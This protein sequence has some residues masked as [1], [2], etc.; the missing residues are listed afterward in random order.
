MIRVAPAMILSLALVSSPA[1][2]AVAGE[3]PTTYAKSSPQRLAR[4]VAR[5]VDQDGA[6]IEGV[7]VRLTRCEGPRF[8]VTSLVPSLAPP[9]VPGTIDTNC[10]EQTRTTGEDGEASFP[11]VRVGSLSVDPSAPRFTYVLRAEKDGYE[12]AGDVVTPHPARNDVDLVMFRGGS[13][14]LELVERA[15]AAAATGDFGAA[16]GAMSEAL[17]VLFEQ[18]TASGPVPEVLINWVRYLAHLQV[19]GANMAG[20]RESLDRLLELDPYDPFGLRT[21]GILAVRRQ[22][23]EE[24]RGHFGLYLLL[25]PDSADA[26]LVMGSLLVETNELDD[27]FEHLEQ[28]LELDRANPRVYRSLGMAH[29]RAD[30]SQEAI[31][32]FE[33]YLELAGDPPDAGQIRAVIEALRRNNTDSLADGV[34]CSSATLPTAVDSDTRSSATCG[35]LGCC[36]SPSPRVAA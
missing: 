1:N 25:E 34:A 7:E 30:N 4:V 14:P 12:A 10:R 6:P 22:D 11:S 21:L 26:W 28:A 27:A 32:N 29:Q 36:R 18:Y 15:Q 8:V 9:P 13:L 31:A 17:D 20:A 5:V 3:H 33:R 19:Q 2:P 23:W 16:E 24:A 35:P